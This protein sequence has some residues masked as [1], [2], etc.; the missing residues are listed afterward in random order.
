M[1]SMTGAL[2]CTTFDVGYRDDN[3]ALRQR[4]T[5]LEKELTEAKAQLTPHKPLGSSSNPFLGGPMRL[6]FEG[7]TQGEL[8]ERVMERL[9]SHLRRE[10]G[11]SGRIDRVGRSLAWSTTHRNQTR[12]A[13]AWA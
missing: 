6:V 12:L 11:E 5:Q 3:E 9:V 2:G 1:C 8:D 10:L 7:E 13:A 4:L